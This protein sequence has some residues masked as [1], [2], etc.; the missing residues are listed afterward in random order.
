MAHARTLMVVML[1]ALGLFIG[2]GEAAHAQNS[3]TP[4]T[5]SQ[6]ATQGCQEYVG[7]SNRIVMCLRDTLEHA[8]DRFYDPQT[9]LYKYVK[10]AIGGFL[11]LVVIV[12]GILAAY[13]MLEKPGRDI[14]ILM[15][16]LS[17][18]TVF[19]VNSDVMYQRM[20]DLMDNASAAVVQF[21]PST[22]PAVKGVDAS[23]LE[24][25]N[26]MHRAA[27]DSG[28][29]YSAAWLGMDCVIDS[30]IG[31]KIPASLDGTAATKGVEA[32]TVNNKLGEQPGMARGLI[33]FFF[34]S[35]QSSI[36]GVLLAVVGFVFMYSLIW[37]VLKALFVYLAGYIGIAFMMI[38]APVFIPLI[39]FRVTSEYFKKWVK[40][41]IAFALQ[42][43]IILAFV[44]FSVTAIDLAMFSG[45]Y[46]VM[47]RIAGE[48][49]RA[50]NFNLNKY[51]EDNKIV[52]KTPAVVAQ[53]KTSPTSPELKVID[54][55]GIY[56][57]LKVS[58]CGERME[59]ASSDA[60][61]NPQALE[62]TLAE[63]ASYPIQYWHDSLNWNKMAEKRN[64]AVTP[65]PRK[66]D[67]T[68]SDGSVTKGDGPNVTEAD[69]KGRAIAR[70][71]FASIMF[72]TVV[73]LCINGLLTV[74]PSMV[75]DLIGE[76]FQSPNLFNEVS[77]NG[78]GGGIGGA[79][80]N[81]MGGNRGGGG[82]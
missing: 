38:F 8:T 46:S 34:S 60:N 28:S 4:P 17:M 36:L 71:V 39:L 76:Q 12:Y 55:Q 27:A 40:L 47:Y 6:N 20:L 74:I 65:A 45:D 31:I 1:L 72:V 62:K 42:P 82:R 80:S 48:A 14:M 29:R 33:S 70:E 68:N 26:N 5:G 52:I 23:R 63:C 18:V 61:A 11:T 2:M 15:F 44:S 3:I 35:M 53:V 19:V 32:L 64:P 16:K 21:T 73:V 77:R 58:D 54:K 69:L 10:T 13:G 7:L 56:K 51:L 41:S 50:S 66:A 9:G 57:E 78:K 43:V 81:M 75:N 37:L 22:G 25:L 67:V 30:V 59:K 24:C 79:L 49:S